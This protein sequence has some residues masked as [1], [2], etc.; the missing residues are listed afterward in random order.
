MDV[1]GGFSDPYMRLYLRPESDNKT[2]QTSVKKHTLNPVY[3]EY[4]KFPV[5]FEELPEKTLHIEAYDFDKFSRHDV[6]GEV[7]VHLEQVDVSSSVEVWSD[8]EKVT[9]VC[10]YSKLP[11]ASKATSVCIVVTAKFLVSHLLT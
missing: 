7:Q 6:I 1:F 10:I 5:A 3:D 9:E 2:R 4:F 11:F 8:I